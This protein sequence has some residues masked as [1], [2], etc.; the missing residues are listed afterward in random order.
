MT[1]VIASMAQTTSAGVLPAPW[2]PPAEYSLD[3]EVQSKEDT[4]VIHRAVS[5]GRTRSVI[6]LPSGEEVV[7][8]ELA[9]DAGTVY[10]LL[11]ELG[12]GIKQTAATAEALAHELEE[13]R[14][15]TTGEL[16]EDV[17]ITPA[18]IQHMKKQTV[19]GVPCNLYAITVNGHTACTWNDVETQRP[20]RMQAGDNRIFWKNYVA[21]P[22]DEELF[23]VPADYEIQDMDL[24][25]EDLNAA[26]MGSIVEAVPGPG[27]MNAWG[28]NGMGLG[29]A[30]Q[31]GSGL[32]AGFDAGLA[33]ALD[34]TLGAMASQY[35]EG[36]VGDMLGNEVEGAR[37][38]APAVE[39]QVEE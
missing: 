15:E 12:I 6:E 39:E 32:G 30:A 9:D 26:G 37:V 35:L 28:G 24:L 31:L 5:M 27:G 38:E 10:T 20:V 23:Q 2:T 18:Q 22:Q 34:G 13:E 1:W 4:F 11:P 19:D 36:T 25:I 29:I 7:V 3:M 14:L 21:G 17:A 16:E 8:L 33:T